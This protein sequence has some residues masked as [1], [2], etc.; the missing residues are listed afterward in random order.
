MP[1]RPSFPC[2]SSIVNQ[3]PG[4]FLAQRK[5]LCRGVPLARTVKK[6]PRTVV[7]LPLKL[8]RI[9][10]PSVTS[11]RPSFIFSVLISTDVLQNLV[12]VRTLK[13]QN[14][15][16]WQITNGSSFKLG[17]PVFFGFGEKW[18]EL[19]CLSKF[20]QTSS[21]TTYFSAG[22]SP[23]KFEDLSRSSWQKRGFGTEIRG[24]RSI[25]EM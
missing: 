7:P 10:R 3:W 18:A 13:I 20:V 17:K 19:I 4:V 21:C 16:A 22:S 6:L 1:R 23:K 25:A 2:T 5:A 8:R 12:P 15:S 11:E 9:R 14:S 24:G